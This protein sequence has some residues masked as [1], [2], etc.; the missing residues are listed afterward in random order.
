MPLPITQSIDNKLFSLQPTAL[1]N[2]CSLCDAWEKACEDGS[3][4][5]AALGTVCVSQD[6]RCY[7]QLE[8]DINNLA[9]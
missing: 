1:V 6:T 9:W 8:L 2:Q 5:C 3:S 4:L 7:W